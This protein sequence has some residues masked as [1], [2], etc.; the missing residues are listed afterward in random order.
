MHN[1]AR[2]LAHAVHG[3]K[4]VE[5]LA[6]VDTYFELFQPERRERVI[7]NGGDLRLVDYVQLSVADDVDVR[8][9]EFSEAAALRALAAVHL[10]DL[11]APEWEAQLRVVRGDVFCQRD[12]QV[13]AQRKVA[14]A[15]LEAVYLLFRLPAALGQQHLRRLDNG[16]VERG[17]A[18]GGVAAAQG[19]LHALHLHLL[20]G[21]QLHKAGERAR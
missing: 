19:I 18:I 15:L 8:L 11:A 10:A 5:Y 13:K 17:E 1:V 9:I 4:A 21:Q 7:D 2:A 12:G 6:V 16:R 3:V 20:C 14:V